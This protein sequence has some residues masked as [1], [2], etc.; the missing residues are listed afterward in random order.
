[1][2]GAQGI[3]RRREKA[4]THPPKVHCWGVF[5]MGRRASAKDI[6][7]SLVLQSRWTDPGLGPSGRNRC[8][9][10]A[11]EA[12]IPLVVQQGWQGLGMA[13]R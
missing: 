6:P 7:R 8:V 2:S 13:L 4:G 1:M 5:S 3:R 12:L 9:P 10:R 11:S